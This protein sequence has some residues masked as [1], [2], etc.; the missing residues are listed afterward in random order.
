MPGRARVD[1][2]AA[3]GVVLRDVRRAAALAATGDKVGGVIVLVGA[4]GEER[5][6]VLRRFYRAERSR[7]NI[8]NWR[9]RRDFELLTSRFVVQVGPSKSLRSVTVRTAYLWN[10]SENPAS[11][12]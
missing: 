4:H 9:A 8:S 3:V 2:R 10:P 7:H 12:R 11:L 5:E 1:R 6:A